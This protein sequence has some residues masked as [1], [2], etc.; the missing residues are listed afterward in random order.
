MFKAKISQMIL[1]GALLS[2]SFLSCN[3]G[4]A[5]NS[6]N[7]NTSKFNVTAESFADLELL[8]YQVNGWDE[9]TAQQ[10]ELAYYLYEAS[11]SGRDIIYDQRGKYGLTIRKTI[12]AIWQNEQIDR[13]TE[14]WNNFET[15]S[16]QVWFSNGIHHHYSNDKFIPQFSFEYFSELVNNAEQAA[17]PLNEGENIDDFLERIKPVIF[18]ADYLPKAI[19]TRVGIDHIVNSANN[20]YEGVTE[21]EVIDFYAQFPQSDHE[22]EWGLNSKLVKENG[23]IKEKVWKS[24]GMYGEAIDRII[25]WLEKAIPVAENEE[26]ATALKLLVEYYKTGDLKKWDEYN[27][28]WVKDTASVID[29]INGFIEVY[30]DAIGKKGS[31]ESI[32]SLRDFESTERIKAIADQA[33]WFEDN[34]PLF[35]EH[36]KKDVKGISAKAINVIV[37]SGDAAPSTPIGV[38]LPNSDWIRK[39]H[40]SKSVSLSN[41]VNAYNDGS[42]NSGFLDEFIHNQEVLDRLKKYG[43]LAGNL[44]TDMHECIGHASGQINPGVGTPDK[45]LKSYASAL[46]EARADLVSLYYFLDQ[47]LVDIGVMP[48]L[49]VGKAEYDSYMMNGLMTQLTRLNVGDD[50]QQAHMR[51]RALNAYWVY[52]KGKADNVVELIK[53]NGKTYVQIND[54]EKLRV[55]F[56]E[57]LREIQRIKSEGDYEAGKN[58]I[59]TYAVKV[60]QE[61]HQEIKDRFDALNVKAYKGF[62]QAKL[63]PEMKD[64]KVVDVHIEYPES[65]FDQMMEYGKNYGFLPA[66]N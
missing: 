32:L 28:A 20:F 52:E 60:N 50:I 6:S 46:E 66:I 64:G 18:D 33:Q 13:S 37:E 29:L 17:L 53:E 44:H 58:L 1:S 63:V 16:G 31:F 11:L 3:S 25:Y 22:P 41:I 36:K 35:E 59:E 5:T 19:D 45:T 34:S 49:E 51:N 8:R 47:K 21:K 2:F 65:F 24:G 39:D 9:L 15:Y 55:L 62:I 12:E 54:Y 57:L 23:Q 43:N 30:G 40:G 48:S 42:A 56:G 10:K 61:L 7:Q 14:E 38:N 27:V 26:Q 4:D